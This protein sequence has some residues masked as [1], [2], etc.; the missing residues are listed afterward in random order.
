MERTDRIGRQIALVGVAFVATLLLLGGAYAILSARG[1]EPRATGAPSSVS[2][3]P[4]PTQSPATGSPGSGSAGPIPSASGDAGSAPPDVTLTGAGDIASCG[5]R[6]DSATSDLLVGQPGTIFTAGDNAYEDGSPANFESCYA[7]TWGR[8][9]DRTTLPAPG[10][11]DWNTAGAAGYLAYF[12]SAAAPNGTTWYSKDL[13]AWHVIVLDSDC[14]KVDGCDAGSPQGRWLKADLAAHASTRC[15][16]AIWHHPRFSSGEHGNDP[17]VGPFWE[18]LVAAHADLVING[19]DHDYERFAPQNAAGQEDRVTGLR[20]FVVGTGGAVLRGFT[21]V[22]A[23]SELRV[24]GEWGVI[25]LTLHVAN[26]DWEFLPVTGK[27]TDSGSALC[28]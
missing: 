28:H 26:Y 5:L 12:G 8:V 4:P 2:A 10:N 17:V 27:V 16:L 13:G 6:G 21:K 15:T 1:D 18:Q 11:H 3:A 23:N 22:A 14:A 19:H 25:R 20:Q 9:L 7:P 24:G